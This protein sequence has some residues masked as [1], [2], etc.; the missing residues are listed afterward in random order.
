MSLDFAFLGFIAEKDGIRYAF[1]SKGRDLLAPDTYISH[2]E[3]GYNL[4]YGECFRKD[5]CWKIKGKRGTYFYSASHPV[6]MKI[7]NQEVVV[8]CTRKTGNGDIKT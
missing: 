4:Y 2:E 7:Y 5:F 3:L 8:S 1:N 6:L